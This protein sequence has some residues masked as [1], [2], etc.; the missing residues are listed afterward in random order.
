MRRLR[1][2][3]KGSNAPSLVL[4]EVKV[5]THSKIEHRINKW[6]TNAQH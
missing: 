2:G 5:N 1:N 6:P 3:W 4:Q